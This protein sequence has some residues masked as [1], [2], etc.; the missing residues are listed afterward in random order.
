M[1][2]L[3]EV[4]TTQSVELAVEAGIPE[5]LDF[6][7]SADYMTFEGGAVKRIARIKMRETVKA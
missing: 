1:N 5:T 7:V 2:G 4:R 6:V 3:R